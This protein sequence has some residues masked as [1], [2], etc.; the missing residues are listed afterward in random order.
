[1]TSRFPLSLL[2][3][4]AIAAPVFAAPGMDSTHI[5]S[6]SLLPEEVRAEALRDAANS[7]I[8]LRK[9]FDVRTRS[10]TLSRLFDGGRAFSTRGAVRGHLHTRRRL[11]RGGPLIAAY[12]KTSSLSRLWT[13]AYEPSA[14][15][16]MQRALTHAFRP[17]RALLE[18]AWD[19]AWTGSGALRSFDILK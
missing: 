18:L 17:V 9:S 7:A 1:M 19:G 14:Q 10:E 4:A 5:R 8:D 16:Q 12:E 2:L 13:D 11:R 15:E 6:G 3:T